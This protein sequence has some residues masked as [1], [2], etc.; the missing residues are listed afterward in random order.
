VAD[1][2]AGATKLGR[3]VAKQRACQPGRRAAVQTGHGG[4]RQIGLD[5]GHA[6]GPI[7]GGGRPD[8]LRSQQ[9]RA[10][11]HSRAAQDVTP[12][13]GSSR[14]FNWID[15]ALAPAFTSKAA[16]SK[17]GGPMLGRAPFEKP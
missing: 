17:L 5:V 12:V 8:G 9:G 11:Q 16:A 14:Y 7:V 4:W 1:V 10:A 13:H 15:W 6:Q 3:A 2:A